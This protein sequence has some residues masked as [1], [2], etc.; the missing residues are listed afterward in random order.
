MTTVL[1]SKIFDDCVGDADAGKCFRDALKPYR[2]AAERSVVGYMLSDGFSMPEYQAGLNS[3]IL[4]LP[5]VSIIRSADEFNG[6]QTAKFD[7]KEENGDSVPARSL[8]E[9]NK[10]V[11]SNYR[12]LSPKKAPGIE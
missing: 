9:S 11:L 12:K 4:A 6:D 8:E 2:G 10:E 5:G 3:L 7:W 1:L